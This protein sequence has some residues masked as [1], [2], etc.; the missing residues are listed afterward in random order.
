MRHLSIS[1]T[2]LLWAAAAAALTPCAARAD[3]KMATKGLQL[4]FSGSG[5]GVVQV[6]NRG[7]VLSI[8]EA[9]DI[10]VEGKIRLIARPSV[11][12]VL[13]KWNGIKCSSSECD[14]EAPPDQPVT[15]EFG[16]DEK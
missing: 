10:E 3:E 2:G 14:L 9:D 7:G 11:G 8:S 1:V 15:V 6:E 16:V 13:V 12:S 5:S 4:R